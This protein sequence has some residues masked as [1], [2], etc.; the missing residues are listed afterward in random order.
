MVEGQ[1]PRKVVGRRE[2]IIAW[3]KQYI[4]MNRFDLKAYPPRREPCRLDY[5]PHEESMLTLAC[6]RR[7][8][9]QRYHRST[10][11]VPSPPGV[12]A[13]PCGKFLHVGISAIGKP[14][15]LSRR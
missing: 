1:S 14:N 9:W 8:N 2:N 10:P 15:W 6:T 7:R 5:V 13:R 11:T 4:P 3:D 12:H